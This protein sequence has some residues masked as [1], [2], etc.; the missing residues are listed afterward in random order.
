MAAAVAAQ[1][2]V[3]LV[4]TS[5]RRTMPSHRDLHTALLLVQVVPVQ[6]RPLKTVDSLAV[7]LA[8]L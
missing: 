2:L 3:V 1:V 8:S 5:K 4:D 6:Q 7:L